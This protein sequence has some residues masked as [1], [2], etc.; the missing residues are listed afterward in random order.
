MRKLKINPFEYRFIEKQ[1]NIKI[2]NE[3]S[4]L[5]NPYVF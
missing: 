3:V 5:K 2:F 4:Q 1:I